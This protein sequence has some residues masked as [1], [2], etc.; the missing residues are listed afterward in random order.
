MTTAQIA[1]SIALGAVAVFITFFALYVVSSTLWGDRWV[2]KP[3]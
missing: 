1:F 2:R 3:R